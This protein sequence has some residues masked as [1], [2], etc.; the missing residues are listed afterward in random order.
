MTHAK[1]A[2][3]T[4]AKKD[5]NKKKL[6]IILIGLLVAVAIMFGSMFAFFSD[7]ITGSTTIKI[8]TLDLDKGDASYKK[9]GNTATAT[10][11]LNF[12]PGD[13]IVVS[14]A[15]KNE[16]SKSA[17]LRGIVSITGD[18]VGTVA[19]GY[20]AFDSV[21]EVYKGDWTLTEILDGDSDVTAAKMTLV[22]NPSAYELTWTDDDD[23][24]AVINADPSTV[25]PEIEKLAASGGT[26]PA[27]T[28]IYDADAGEVTYTIFFKG[29]GSLNEWQ[30]KTINL[31]C[32]AEAVQYRNN[33]GKNWD[34]LTLTAF[35]LI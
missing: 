29:L 8:G 4:E 14:T 31:N 1:H 10:E 2:K 20:T 16:G 17:W 19:D 9:N 18:A 28:T 21:F 12:N 24:L 34:D 26:V 23:E 30:D 32:K 15:V 22:Q 25:D 3:H 35:S 7:I 33:A 6:G 5:N 27:G 11:L 13:V